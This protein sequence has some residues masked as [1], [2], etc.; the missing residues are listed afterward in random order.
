MIDKIQD[1]CGNYFG[2]N[3]VDYDFYVV[4]Y[5]AIKLADR[6]RFLYIQNTENYKFGGN[7]LL[8]IGRQR[9][10]RDLY[11]N[12]FVLDNVV[13]IVYIYV[14]RRLMIKIDVDIDFQ[15]YYQRVELLG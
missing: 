1:V 2:D 11:I 8:V 3:I 7:L 9:Y 13:M 14:F 10:E 15:Y 5:I 12:K 4:M 6:L